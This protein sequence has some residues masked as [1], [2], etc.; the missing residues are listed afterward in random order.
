ME[1][2]GTYDHTTPD[3]PDN[4]KSVGHCCGKQKIYSQRYGH[5]F[6]KIKF[7]YMF[8]NINSS[9]EKEVVCVTGK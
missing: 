5:I 3:I 6:I 8:V 1:S 7:T 4:K 2:W 9:L